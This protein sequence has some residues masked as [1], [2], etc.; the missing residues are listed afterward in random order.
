MFHAIMTIFS[1]YNSLNNSIYIYEQR[2]WLYRLPRRMP[3]LKKRKGIFG[4][5][6]L[7][8]NPA[9]ASTDPVFT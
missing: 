5:T 4:A 3:A 1:S 8:A 9:A 7:R 6:A 2:A